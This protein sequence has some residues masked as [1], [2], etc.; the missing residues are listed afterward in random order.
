MTRKITFR[1]TQ[2]G[3]TVA[4]NL[5]LLSVTAHAQAP[6]RRA[7]CDNFSPTDHVKANIKP[8]PSFN[9]EVFYQKVR[10]KLGSN[11]MGYAFILQNQQSDR[12][13]VGEQGYGRTPC[14]ADGAQLFTIRTKTVWGSV[15][16]MVTFTAAMHRIE[17]VQSEPLGLTAAPATP[18]PSLNAP[19]QTFLPLRWR[20]SLHQGFIKPETVTIR[21]LLEHRAGFQ[22]SGSGTIWERLSSGPETTA[23]VGARHYSNA[24]A[25]IFQSMPFLLNPS[26][27]QLVEDQLARSSNQDYNEAVDVQSKLIYQK[28]VQE[29]I[30]QPLDIVAKC[31]DSN[32]PDGKY[33]MF[34]S[35]TTQQMGLKVTPNPENPKCAP[36]GWVLSPLSMGKFAHALTQ[37]DKIIAK[38]TYA[39]MANTKEQEHRL[40]WASAPTFS[41][42]QGFAHNGSRWSGKAKAE[43]IVFP[44]GFTAVGATNSKPPEGCSCS[45]QSAF[46]EAYEAALK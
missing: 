2:V 9:T 44:N 38:T 30:W 32:F 40:G 13:V 37:T 24:S 16:K 5:T 10:D 4:F 26:Q 11:Y 45:L 34:Y 23:G 3:L 1:L 36:G 19:M 21:H 17:K 42:G 46:K 25:G 35:S 41:D 8:Q 29:N 33:A 43:M 27:A 7:T 22:K 18:Q 20:D 28:Y 15:S 31:N 39:Q 12:I 14:E 6:T